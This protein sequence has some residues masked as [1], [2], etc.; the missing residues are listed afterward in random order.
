VSQLRRRFDRSAA[1]GLPA[2]ITALYPFLDEDRLTGAVLDQLRGLCAEL[3]RL[4]VRFRRTDRFARVLYLAPEPADGLCRLTAAIVERWPEAPP[5]CG[6]FTEIVP[7]LTIADDADE[8][9]MTRIAQEVLGGL[10][11]HARLSEAYLYVFDGA[12]WTPR[13]RLPFGVG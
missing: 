10:P 11:V 7:H 8:D 2:H 13:A 4:D 5:Y 3:P 1:Q 12:S 6:A 9:L